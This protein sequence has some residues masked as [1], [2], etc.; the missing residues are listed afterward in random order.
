V[1]VRYEASLLQR[2]LVDGYHSGSRAVVRHDRIP[3]AS[4]AACQGSMTKAHVP[5]MVSPAGVPA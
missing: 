3:L 5:A 2:R 4:S 1:L